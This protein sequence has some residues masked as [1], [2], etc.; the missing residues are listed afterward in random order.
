[1]D[2]LF[3]FDLFRKN[4]YDNNKMRNKGGQ[5][6]NK[7]KCPGCGAGYNGRR[8]ASCGYEPFGETDSCRKPSVPK[9]ERRKRPL[10]RF[11]VLLYLIYALLPLFREWG[12][13]L[14]AMEDMARQTNSGY[15]SG[16]AH[17]G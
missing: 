3:L 11:L 13:K 16:E 12:L 6:V 9:R 10:L 15:H 2:G 1:M 14:E 8:C 17:H 7:T 4:W 5:T